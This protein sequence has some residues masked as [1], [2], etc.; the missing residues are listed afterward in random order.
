MSTSPART[1]LSVLVLTFIGIGAGAAR[2]AEADPSTS[3]VDPVAARTL[4][5]ERQANARRQH[6]GRPAVWMLVPR[7][8]KAGPDG[9]ARSAE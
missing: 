5:S 4:V 9:P 6:D 8:P 7:G 2:A 3:A 1:G